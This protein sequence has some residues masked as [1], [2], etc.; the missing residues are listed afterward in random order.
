MRS[1]P[2]GWARHVM[3]PIDLSRM[4]QRLSAEPERSRLQ[5]VAA[6]ALLA[7]DIRPDP[8][9]R[10]P[11]RRDRRDDHRGARV[12]EL[13]RLALACDRQREVAREVLGAEEQRDHAIR[14]GRDRVRLEQSSRRFDR[15]DDANRAARDPHAIFSFVELSGEPYNFIGPV[16][17]RCDDALEARA[18]GG[19]EIPV[20]RLDVAVHSHVPRRTHF[21]R[22]Q[23]EHGRDR[24]ARV[25][26]LLRWDAV[27]EVENRDVESV[28]PELALPER[29]RHHSRPLRGHEHQRAQQLHQYERGMPSTFWP[30][31]AS[32]RLLLTGATSSSRVS[33]NLRSTSY[34]DAKP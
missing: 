20:A 11:T 1:L 32:T 14:A 28:R 4:D 30:R 3:D 27:L 16:D 26:L 6:E 10:M 31:Y 12:E 17:L 24:R 19:D 25:I 22:G 23:C 13:A 8:V 33:R 5:R 7:N 29:A 21:R 9:D 34:S 2:G 15:G 18:H